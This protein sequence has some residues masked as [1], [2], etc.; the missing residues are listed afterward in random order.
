MDNQ[1]EKKLKKKISEETLLYRQINFLFINKMWKSVNPQREIKEL[2][3]MLGVTRNYYSRVMSGDTY[4]IPDL[5][6][7]WNENGKSGLHVLGLPKEYMMGE[8]VIE[9]DY[10]NINNWKKYLAVR[11]DTK[12]KDHE[13]ILAEFNSLFRKEINALKRVGLNPNS[14][15]TIDMLYYFVVTGDKGGKNAQDVVIR[16]LIF[17]LENIPLLRWKECD[18]ELRKNA[19]D[20][21]KKQLHIATTIQDYENLK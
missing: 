15:K 3:D 16:N 9:M 1:P 8:K 18:N 2:Y 14:E 6:R 17:T 13:Y 4:N 7:K 19:I 10:I 5:T 20:K 21:L 11:N 12:N